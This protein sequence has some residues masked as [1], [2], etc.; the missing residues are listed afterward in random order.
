ML[1]LEAGPPDKK[2]EI[3]IPA[4]FNKLFKSKFD[5]AYETEPQPNLD[6]RAMFWPRGK[7]LGGSSSLNAQMYVRGNALDYDHWE[8][9]G[10]RDGR[11]ATSSPTS[12]APNAPSA[13]PRPGAAPAGR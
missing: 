13:A 8:D 9:L 4:A 10:T 2:L 6:G 11:T 1:L 5:W 3:R 7:T 12:S